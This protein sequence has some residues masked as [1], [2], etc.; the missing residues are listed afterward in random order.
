MVY[1]P[2][3]KNGKWQTLSLAEQMG[4][5]GSEISRAINWKERDEELFEKAIE[6]GL[7]LLD[8]T[9]ADPRWRKRLKE[10]VRVREFICDSVFGDKEYGN[11][12]ED[13]DRY[14][15]SFALAARARK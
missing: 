12:L 4:N 15:L 5:I 6:R 3:L 13:F 10:I 7:E 11:S 14:F 2:S 8:F 9:I 1:H